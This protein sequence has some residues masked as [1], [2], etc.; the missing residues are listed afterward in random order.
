LGSGAGS[1][2]QEAPPISART[3]WIG[4]R[5]LNAGLNRQE[6]VTVT[7]GGLP[8]AKGGKSASLPDLENFTA[9]TWDQIREDYL[10]PDGSLIG[11]GYDVDGIFG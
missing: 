4:R 11:F 2:R 5:A 10:Y 8:F 6:P 1:L 7:F 3:H 9:A